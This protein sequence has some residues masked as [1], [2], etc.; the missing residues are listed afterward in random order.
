MLIKKKT[1]RLL[2]QTSLFCLNPSKGMYGHL[3]K[4][5]LTIFVKYQRTIKNSTNITKKIF[6]ELRFYV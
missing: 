3:N 6:L 1:L 4:L 5:V 2:L